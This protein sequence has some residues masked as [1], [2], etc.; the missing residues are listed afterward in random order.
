M[1]DKKQPE[2]DG[3]S[4]KAKPSGRATTI[5]GIGASAGGLAALKTFFDNVPADSGLSFVVVVHLAPEYKSHL[6]DLLQPHASFRILQVNETVALEPN[7]AY[8]IPPNANISTVDTHLRLSDLEERRSQ[9][10]PID[11]FF[12][13]LASTHDGHAIGVI[14]TGSGADGTLGI[15]DIKARGGVV[16]VQDPS[17]AEYDGMPQSAIATGLAD[18]ILPV[19]QI[20]SAILRFDRATP[21]VKVPDD[22]EELVD[23]SE[24]ML[25]QK[26]FMHLRARTDRDFSR[27]NRSTVLRRIARRMQLNYIENLQ[28]YVDRLR[29]QPEETRALADDLLVTVTNFFRDTAVFEKLQKDVIPRLFDKKESRDSVRLWSV[30]C[31]TGEEAYSLAILL[32]EEAGRR[33]A[34]PQIQLFASDLHGRSLQRAREGFYSGDIETDVGPERLKRFFAR[35]SGGFRVRHE[36]R[37][38]IVFAPHN[39]LGD[40]P[41]SR[42]D[43]ISCRNLLIYLQRDVQR[44]V[45]DLFHYALN[46]DGVLL[47]G[48]AETIE[49][50]DLFRCEDKRF[51]LYRKRNV[52]VPEPRLPVFPL[53]RLRVPGEEDSKP[54]EPLE[55]VSYGSLHQRMVELYAPPSLLVSADNKLVH[56]SAHG[57]RY[58]VHPGGEPTANIFKLVREE[59]RIELQGLLQSVRE[60]KEACDSEPIPVS[61]EGVLRPVLLHVRPAL[62]PNQEGFALII[63][64]EREP[65]KSSVPEE[66]KN[67]AE[68]ATQIDR[69]LGDFESELSLSRSRLRAI[70]EEY[71]TSQEEM[72]ASNEEMQSTNEELRSTMEELETSK[73]ELQSINEE[74]QTVNQ[75]N[76]HKVEELAQLSGDLHN[77]LSATGIATLFL[78]RNL[79]I[80]RFTPKV[81]ELF[82]VRATDRGRPI[83]DLTHRLGYPQLQSDSESVL[84]NLSAIEREVRDDG[85]GWY[86]TRV[87][88]Y[89]SSEDRIDGVVIT[90]VDITR[91][92]AA[93]TALL[94]SQTKLLA[95]LN[96]MQRLQDLV[97]RLFVSSDLGEALETVLDAAMGI[98]KAD[99]GN[100]QLLD[101]TTNNLEML[102]SSGFSEEFFG[103]FQT[104]AGSSESASGRAMKSRMR[105]VIEDIAADPFYAPFLEIAAKV[106]YRS[107]QATPLISRSGEVLGILSTQ[108]PESRAL[109]ERDFRIL[110][111]YA[112][113]ASDFVERFRAD[114]RL[115]HSE[116][117]YR[118]LIE[119]ARE[120]AIFML[121]PGGQVAIWSTGA[122][123][124]FG[125]TE[126]EM[127]GRSA[128]ILYPEEDRATGVLM[129]EIQTATE[130]GRSS[131]DRWLVRKDGA[132]FW[133]IGFMEALD[134][135]NG[136]IGGYVKVLRDDSERKNAEDVLRQKERNLLLANEALS[137]ANMNLKQ[138]AFAASHDLR[139]P[140]RTIS[141]STRLL[142]NATAHGREKDAE[143]AARFILEGTQRMEQLLADLLAYTQLTVEEEEISEFVDL[144][145]V[146]EKTLDNLKTQID[147]SEARITSAAL[148]IVR[149]RESHYVQ[150]F[151]NLISN[152]IKY[153]SERAPEIRIS[154]EREG[155]CWRISVSD[156]GMGIDAAYHEQVFGVF[157]RLH[158]SKIP[159]TGIGLAICRRVV[160]LFGGSIWVESKVEDGSTFFFTLPA[161]EEVLVAGRGSSGV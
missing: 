41:F 11:H 151:Q 18:L 104:L 120:Y 118:L 25:L 74:L 158:S 46:P 2:P 141:A 125:Y 160:E 127:I 36:L 27:Y 8:V 35:E 138:F 126:Q 134:S 111:L 28:A 64:E 147:Q 4:P 152:A 153:R 114:E 37:D 9:R 99:M 106:G 93:E 144:N 55:P 108:A 10:A 122:E 161:S 24:V 31:A 143:K 75:E 149:G 80:Q 12:R 135:T 73:E 45:A 68:D 112:R 142:I 97:N 136:N 63:F 44:A 129:R 113:Q 121:N 76:R 98:M 103:H 6:A 20:P 57:G 87:L 14:L 39:L 34:P 53:T 17:E 100:I 30:G 95:E 49:A 146:V 59:L 82:N 157:K 137:R 81:A 116:E 132:K 145:G 15:K 23:R 155:D 19:E 33:E 105:V 90:F 101:P 150:L 78:D 69:R 61:F 85:D 156:N 117:R 89:R 96:A 86:L 72:K 123:R 56:L 43:F 48:A 21:N 66:A 110:N 84:N 128:N 38:L 131:D 3:L 50:V 58:L 32:L 7:H 1:T 29:D 5:V 77:L 140:L 22:G 54:R 71:E 124:V 67:K 83:S 102:A 148:P 154:A 139:E 52:P 26:V 51:C 70:I 133:A 92:V 91:R 60:T 40:P 107:V 115:R 13:T 16:I 109:S 119:N 94:D 62:E 88:P 130:Q 79:R 159:G 47:L 42:V 65:K